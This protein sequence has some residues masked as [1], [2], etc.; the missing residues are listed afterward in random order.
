MENTIL[1]YS[2]RYLTNTVNRSACINQHGRFPRLSR[3]IWKN[4]L[5]IDFDELDKWVVFEGDDKQWVDTLKLLEEYQK[6]HSIDSLARAAIMWSAEKRAPLLDGIRVIHVFH[7]T[8]EMRELF[9]DTFFPIVPNITNVLVCL[10]SSS[11]SHLTY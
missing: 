11:M 6:S 3:E 8:Q 4:T 9:G 2:E 7:P 1:F 5:S 10:T